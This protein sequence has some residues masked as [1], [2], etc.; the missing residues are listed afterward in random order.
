MALTRFTLRQLE[1]F[2]AVAE[3]HSFRSAAER[4]ALTTQAVSQLVA[5]LE[6]VLGFRLFDR[7]R[8]L[9]TVTIAWVDMGIG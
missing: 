5:E 7:T 9:C 1:A 6:A 4:M 2:T 8:T 3:L